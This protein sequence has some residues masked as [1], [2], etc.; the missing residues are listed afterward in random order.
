MP[1]NFNKGSWWL[2]ESAKQSN[3]N[4]LIRDWLME[5]AFWQLLG[6]EIVELGPGFASMRL[7]VE[8]KLKQVLGVLQGGVTASLVD[9]AIV[10]ALFPML[11]PGEM[12][13]TVELKI[14]YLRPVTEGELVTE[15]RIL[16]RGRSLGF[17]TAEVR[18]H[19]G[20]LV[21]H[22]TATC[23]IVQGEGV[24]LPGFPRS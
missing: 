24:S 7:T 11:N 22:G 1:P 16:K 10:A 19:E 14:N 5:S 12:A 4:K 9:A 17:G 20:Q 18:D 6:M 23:M 13:T 3:R 8:E 21:G 2:L 15:A